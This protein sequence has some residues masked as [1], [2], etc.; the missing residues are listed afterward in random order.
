VCICDPFFIFS[1]VGTYPLQLTSITITNYN[2]VPLYS[3]WP[4]PHPLPTRR[5]AGTSRSLVD[6]VS[7]HAHPSS[8]YRSIVLSHS[9]ASAHTKTRTY[10]SALCPSALVCT[11][12]RQCLCYLFIYFFSPLLFSLA[13]HTPCTVGQQAA[14]AEQRNSCV[15][16]S[17]TRNIILYAARAA[18][19]TDSL[20][21]G[22]T[23]LTLNV[24]R[25][26]SV[27]TAS[28][29]ARRGRP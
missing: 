23:A 3:A 8:R 18:F 15:D 7:T 22:G 20:R 25:P 27:F 2:V 21:G 1:F 13:K 12:C 4:V 14:A 9:L 16:R 19:P 24:R 11:R 28:A 6:T 5:L 29:C 26:R 10:S 17:V